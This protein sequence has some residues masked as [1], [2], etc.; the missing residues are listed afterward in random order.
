MSENQRVTSLTQSIA[1]HVSLVGFIA[2]FA[3]VICGLAK[4]D[5]ATE[6][7]AYTMFGVFGTILTQQSSYFFARQRP[8]T[9]QEDKP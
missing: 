2:L 8:D 6:K 7:L 9:K 3:A 5:E 4:L 1:Y